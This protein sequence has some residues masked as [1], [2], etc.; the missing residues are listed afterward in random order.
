MTTARVGQF[1]LADHW[2]LWDSYTE[3]RSGAYV[4]SI[5]EPFYGLKQRCTE[6]GR[7]FWTTEAYRGHYALVHIL[8]LE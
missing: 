5:P 6:C 2:H 4:P 8:G 7:T 3:N 1:K